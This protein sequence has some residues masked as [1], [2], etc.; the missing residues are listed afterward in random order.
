[1]GN[2]TFALSWFFYA[3]VAA[4]VVGWG[5]LL[6]QLLAEGCFYIFGKIYPSRQK[7]QFPLGAGM[8]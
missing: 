2:F 6:V 3:F 7:T 1:M 8:N 4:S 5:I